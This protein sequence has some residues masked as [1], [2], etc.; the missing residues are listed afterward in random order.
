M[1]KCPI[2]VVCYMPADGGAS[3]TYFRKEV[4]G[5]D[6]AGLKILVLPIKLRVKFSSSFRSPSYKPTYMYYRWVSC[7]QS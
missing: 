4:T 1:K 5:D 7:C 3:T 2:V 6:G